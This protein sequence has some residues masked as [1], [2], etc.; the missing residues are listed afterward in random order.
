MEDDDCNWKRRRPWAYCESGGRRDQ[1]K[2]SLRVWR[3]PALIDCLKD[4]NGMMVGVGD[5]GGPVSF[6]GWRRGGG[7][8]DTM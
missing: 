2:K 7:G 1:P 6:G 3:K 5:G 8:R 4:E